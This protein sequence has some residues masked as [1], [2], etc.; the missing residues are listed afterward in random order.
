MSRWL[1]SRMD[2]RKTGDSRHSR[3]AGFSLLE[4]VFVLMLIS[5]MA[6]VGLT[7]FSGSAGHH[8]LEAAAQRVIADI[9]LA[10]NK[11]VALGRTQTVTFTAGSTSYVLDGLPDINSPGQTYATNLGAAPY[12][13][14][15]RS[16]NLDGVGGLVL[17]FNPYGR[18][19]LVQG[20]SA[21]T[22]ILSIG[23]GGGNRAQTVVVDVLTGR[24]YVQE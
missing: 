10:R 7:R 16:L 4:L 13:C 1:G 18:P 14:S 19:M 2:S 17:T 8:G 3:V 21:S 23:L 15:I 9:E 11:A 6:A 20:A 5:I 22:S 24:A 12:E